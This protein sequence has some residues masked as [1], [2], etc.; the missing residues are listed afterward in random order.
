MSTPLIS[1]SVVSHGQIDLVG[2]LL[3]DIEKN[4]KDSTLQFLLTMNLY[5]ALPFE[6]TDFTFPIRV[7]R[8]A[9]P[10]GFAANH[11][12]AFAHSAGQYFCV[13]NPDIRLSSDPFKILLK[14]FEDSSVGV[15]APL[16]LGESGAIEDS[17]RRFPSPLK[18]LCKAFGGCKG[19]DYEIGDELVYPD[20]A[21]GMFL[22]IPHDVYAKVGGFD[23][24][25]FLYY[26]DVD[27]CARL[28]LMGYEIVMSP[29]AQVTHLAQRSSHRNFKYLGWH[30]RS[31]IRFFLS[32]VYCRLA[33]RKIK[34]VG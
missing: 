24:R 16:V 21:G 18:I 3:L 12:Q 4:C 23:Q 33:W 10:L 27:I 8:N 22:L 6:T 30:L 34:T 32:S 2:N 11:N 9:A 26:E 15:A 31:I 25:Y 7:I 19:A 17:V 13:L 28:R 5:E 29:H 1:I 14:C 20:W